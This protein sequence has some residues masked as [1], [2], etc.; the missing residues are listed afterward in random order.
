MTEATKGIDTDGIFRKNPLRYRGYCYDEETGFYYLNAGYY[1]SE[2]RRFISADDIGVVRV[3]PMGL[4]HKN[5][6]AYCDHNPINRIDVTG[7]L[8][9]SIFE[10]TKTV[11]TECECISDR[12]YD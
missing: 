9:S 2:I 7:Q 1:D 5:L 12:W 8:W 4:I 3:A 6:Y 11:V 10:F